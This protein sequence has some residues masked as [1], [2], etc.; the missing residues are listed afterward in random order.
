[1]GH[2]PHSVMVKAEELET[3]DF[4]ALRPSIATVT[5]SLPL[6]C[7][8]QSESLDQVNLMNKL[9]RYLDVSSY[10]VTLQGV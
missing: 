5:W 2:V 10:K 8:G 9:A 1:M 4:K 3:E 7:I 6:H